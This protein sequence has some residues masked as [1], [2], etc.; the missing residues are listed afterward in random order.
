VTALTTTEL[1]ARASQPQLNKLLAE[2]VARARGE[3]EVR[4]VAGTRYLLHP[5]R[6][7]EHECHSRLLP[8][9]LNVQLHGFRQEWG[10]HLVSGE[11]STHVFQ[12]KIGSSVWKRMLGRT[13]ALEVVLRF[14]PPDS[15][16]SSL[17]RV[18]IEITP[19]GLTGDQVSSLLETTGPRLLTSLRSHL[20]AQP[21]RRRQERLVFEQEVP[22]TPVLENGRTGEPVAAQAVNISSGGMHLRMPVRPPEQL[23]IEL[24]APTVSSEPVS[25]P[26][27]VVR[28][29]ECPDGSFDVGV[30]FGLDD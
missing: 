9:A 3:F 14:L 11:D 7:I 4:T 27:R 12:V 16:Q 23:Y 25:M 13:S 20:Q 18:S 10:A 29:E 22:V 30:S 24:T 21:D 5:G 2:V 19:V 6:K 1:A 15:G 8:T 26:A 17:T 28:V